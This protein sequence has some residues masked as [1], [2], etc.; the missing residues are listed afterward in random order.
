MQ[1]GNKMQKEPI[2]VNGLKKLKEELVYLKE[3][4][5]PEIVAAIAE[6]RS[7]GDLKENA[8][9]HAA[10]E[11]QSHNEGRVEEIN[12][13][14]A[15]ANVIDITTFSNDGKIIFGSTV[16]LENLDTGEKLEYKIVG[17]DEADL[18][19]KLIYYKSPVGQGLIGKNKNDLVKIKTPAGVKNF[20]IK[21]VKYI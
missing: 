14:I 10:K 4:K 13:I 7:H 11:Q 17:K 2:T 21:N 1:N 20:E 9:Y 16:D 8:E 5:R 19:N 15:R 3:K 6:A 18:K 12:D